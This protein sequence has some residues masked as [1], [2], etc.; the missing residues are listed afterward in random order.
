MTIKAATF[1]TIS[2]AALIGITGMSE[3]A[4]APIPKMAMSFTSQVTRGSD[5]SHI[6]GNPD[7]AV[8]LVEYVSYTCSHCKNFVEQSNAAL[9]G[10][11]TSG[12]V[13]L[14]VRHLVLSA[15]DIGMTVAAQCGRP[16]RFFSRHDALMA[17]QPSVLARASALTQAQVDRIRALEP[18]PR[19]RAL[20]ADTGVIAWMQRRGFTAP[21]IDSCFSDQAILDRIE[22]MRSA[23]IATGVTGTPTFAINGQLVADAH[24]W[25]ALQ[26]A[27]DR[28]IAQGR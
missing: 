16:D 28:S 21:Q 20:A 1:V 12:R 4:S 9:L 17:L 26:P 10:H 8:K 24:S 13:S 23:A 6:L 14:E 11:I 18:L 5:G 3:S 25:P 2:L 15:P 22:A 19:V 27:L 7:A